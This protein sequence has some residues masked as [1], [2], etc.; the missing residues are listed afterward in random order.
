MRIDKK[1][2]LQETAASPPATEVGLPPLPVLLQ[3]PCFQE[4]TT[5]PATTSSWAAEMLGIFLIF[6]MLAGAIPG[7]AGW[8]PWR[9]FS[10]KNQ[11][12][13]INAEIAEELVLPP[14]EP[15]EMTGASTEREPANQE[16]HED[17]VRQ[18]VRLQPFLE[19]IETGGAP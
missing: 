14:L 19:P 16:T 1:E 7:L 10:Q 12:L 18:R 13:A 4:R 5:G 6:L 2:S 11:D 8:W 3:V 17:V 9:G 15:V